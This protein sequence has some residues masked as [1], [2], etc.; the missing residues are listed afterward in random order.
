MFLQLLESPSKSG[1]FTATQV[2][3]GWSDGRAVFRDVPLASGAPYEGKSTLKRL[4][5]EWRCVTT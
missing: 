3:P 4:V 1:R 5:V 2:E